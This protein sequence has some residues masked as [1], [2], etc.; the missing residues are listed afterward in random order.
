MKFVATWWSSAQSAYANRQLVMAKKTQSSSD[1]N[2][3]KSYIRTLMSWSRFLFVLSSDPSETTIAGDVACLWL[4]LRLK[5]CRS[6]L[7]RKMSW[8]VLAENNQQMRGWRI[9][10]VSFL[11]VIVFPRD[12]EEN[13]QF[14]KTWPTQ[15]ML[16]LCWRWHLCSQGSAC[17]IRL[18][19]LLI[20]QIP[21]CFGKA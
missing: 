5:E 19:F 11:D 13:N 7:G 21:S 17:S 2:H 15:Q 16:F 1:L 9:E 12:S 18:G 6:W 3:I 8:I 14:R 10:E 20:P 4:Q